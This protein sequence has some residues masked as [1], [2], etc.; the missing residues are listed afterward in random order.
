[1]IDQIKMLD[2]QMN[3]LNLKI[4]TKSRGD[5]YFILRFSVS[6]DENQMIFSI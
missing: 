4:T 6:C 5:D 1:M 3:F 2:S